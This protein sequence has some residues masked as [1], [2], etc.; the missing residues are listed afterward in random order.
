MKDFRI[1]IQPD[2]TFGLPTITSEDRKELCALAS[3]ILGIT[4]V[5]NT[6]EMMPSINF[7]KVNL[8]R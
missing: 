3:K 4:N 1:T 8:T 6:G 5:E 7:S 2:G